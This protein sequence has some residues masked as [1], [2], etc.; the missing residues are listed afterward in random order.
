MAISPPP[1]GSTGLPA[2]DGPGVRAGDRARPEHVVDAAGRDRVAA[3]L[4]TAGPATASLLAN[5]L[6]ISTTAVRR[7][8][9]SLVAD[10]WVQ[11]TDRPPY[12]PQPT[13]GRGR[14][15]RTFA[16]TATGRSQFPAEYDTLATEALA[17]VEQV[18]GSDA[19]VA[20]AESRA[21]DLE[22]RLR[23]LLGA[24]WRRATDVEQ[25]QAFAAALDGL[26]FATSVD[27]APTG[28]QVCQHHCPVAHVAGQYPQLCEAET[29]AFARLLGRHVQRLA[30]IAHGDGVCTTVIPL[31]TGT[32]P[33][34]PTT[35]RTSA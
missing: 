28:V 10:G 23:A 12:G 7:H 18:G 29:E 31:T 21:H 3:S 16:L 14:P 30:T 6:G 11:A 19:V 2:G 32:S 17:F 35:E 25:V 4:L 34:S 5:R 27:P 22:A 15:A 8:L 9:D 26:G 20:F 24:D 1:G 13:R 33:D